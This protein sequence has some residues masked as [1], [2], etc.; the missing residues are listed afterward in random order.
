MPTDVTAKLR[1]L[2]VED[3]LIESLEVNPQKLQDHY[4]TI[5]SQFAYWSHQ[6]AI[7]DQNVKLS[8]MEEQRTGA[9]LAITV[10]Q[11]MLDANLKPTESQVAAKVAIDD[12]MVEVQRDRI[13][14]EFQEKRLKGVV[15]ALAIKNQSL[16]SLGAHV[17][18]EM[19][20]D[21]LVRQAYANARALAAGDDDNT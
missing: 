18:K 1:A 20:G 19:D 8:K 17:R 4:T 6:H 3:F 11:R 12:E 5:A 16:M 2:H 21:P 15:A 10:R 7:A 9:V 14:A 13:E